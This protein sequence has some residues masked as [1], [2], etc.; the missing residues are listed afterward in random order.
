MRLLMLFAESF[1]L[2]SAAKLLEGAPDDVRRERVE[3]ATVALIHAEPGDQENQA[4]TVKYLI[5]NI[6]WQA[7]K[8]GSKRAV[9]AYFSHLG[10][11]VAPPE[12]AQHAVET[13]AERLRGAGYEVVVMPFGYLCTWGIEVGGESLARVY[14]EF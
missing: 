9:L 11:E 4:R 5:K 2:E 10:R 3:Q 13:A 7:G 14:K 8:F 12:V 6:K 1:H